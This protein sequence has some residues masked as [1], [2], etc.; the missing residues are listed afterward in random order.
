[1]PKSAGRFN[2][3][4]PVRDV[5]SRRMIRAPRALRFES[6]EDRQM[7]AVFTV[8][9]LND[10]PVAAAG[11]APGTLRQAVFDANSLA[12]ADTIRFTAGLSGDVELS[13]VGDTLFGPTSLLITSVIT[14]EGNA[15]GI[16][17]QRAAGAPEMRLLRVAAS[18]GLT[19]HSI[20]LT[21]G[22]S[23]GSASGADGGQGRGG[24]IYN[25]GTLEI[26]ASTVYGNQA[27]GGNGIGGGSGGS[28]VG[29][30]IYNAGGH[31]TLINATL[32]ANS[33]IGGN[34]SPAG[35]AFGGGIYGIDGHVSILNSTIAES[36][37]GVGRGVYVLGMNGTAHVE[38]QSSIIALG[39]G[40]PSAADVLVA[41]D[42]DGEVSILGENN[43]IRRQ[44]GFHHA[45]D[46][47]PMLGP[48]ANNGGP[49]LTHALL[50]ESPAIQQGSNPSALATDGRGSS[51]A[52]VVD[53]QADIGAFE[54]QTTSVPQ[55][56]GDYNNNHVVDAADYVVWRKTLSNDVALYAGADGS[57]NGTIDT[58]DYTLWR[59]KFGS[60]LPAGGGASTSN[61]VSL[62]AELLPISSPL[63]IA[64]SLAADAFPGSAATAVL[65]LAHELALLDLYTQRTM[66]V[67]KAT[68]V[69][70]EDATVESADTR[71]D[72]LN[73]DLF[74]DD[75]WANWPS[76]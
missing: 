54:V 33:A 73:A 76:E 8:T 14:I 31:V 71:V 19:L 60:V 5:N 50:E 75:F 70:L 49:V 1:M 21:D 38:I 2:A 15:N 48:L 65:Q 13:V 36:S 7:L 42:A 30:A 68:E 67:P 9:N 41:T 37:A 53:G 32:S 3:T 17:L 44:V 52:R 35:S 47:D 72:E 46:T 66:I 62:A 4:C 25:Q 6:L 16:T 12:G 64:R 58:A 61:S 63:P 39:G 29:G 10:A 26:L 34:G 43:L 74:A 59:A 28:G 24:A 45:W 20:M 27:I 18:G 51:Y 55:F 40:T 69:M 56:L 22:I 23:R 11:Q 57:G